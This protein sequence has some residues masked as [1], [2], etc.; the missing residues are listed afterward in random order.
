MASTLGCQTGSADVHWKPSCEEAPEAGAGARDQC[1][2]TGGGG[3]HG[4]AGHH[5]EDRLRITSAQNLD[6]FA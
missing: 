2:Q 4:A 1:I 6:V 3:V 5:V